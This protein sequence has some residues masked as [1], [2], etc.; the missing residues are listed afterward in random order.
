MGKL[1]HMKTSPWAATATDKLFLSLDSAT[2]DRQEGPCG[3]QA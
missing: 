3:V 1:R 2:D